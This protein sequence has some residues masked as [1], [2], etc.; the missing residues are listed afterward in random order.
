VL[1]LVVSSGVPSPQS[2]VTVNGAE[3]LAK[4]LATGPA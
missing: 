4:K 3:L 1:P 2:I